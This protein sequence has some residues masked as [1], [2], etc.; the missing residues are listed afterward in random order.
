MF[1]TFWTFPWSAEKWDSVQ[2][3]FCL[4]NGAEFWRA[5][6]LKSAWSCCRGLLKGSGGGRL[7][8]FWEGMLAWFP[9]NGVIDWLPSVELPAEIDALS[10][11]ESVVCGGD[12]AACGC[13]FSLSFNAVLL[14]LARAFWNQTCF[15]LIINFIFIF[16]IYLNAKK[17]V[18]DYKRQQ[19]QTFPILVIKTSSFHQSL[20]L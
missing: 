2:V 9:P 18:L 11:K 20:S 5:E 17:V 6:N 14:C 3:K 15:L 4:Y 16:F 12:D 10:F 13:V 8:F 7:L 19:L 1:L